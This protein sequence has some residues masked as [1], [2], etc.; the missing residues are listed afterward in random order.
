MISSRT[1]EL[2]NHCWADIIDHLSACLPDEGCGLL[3]GRGDRVQLVYP[4]PNAAAS[5]QRYRMEPQNQLE[6]LYQIDEQG[7]DLVGIFHSHPNG[8]VTPSA[9]DR[10]EWHY[11]ELWMI[12]AAPSKPDWAFGGYILIEGDLVEAPIRVITP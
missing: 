3:A 7:L 10:G 11:N 2:P 8:G 1:L 9:T 12:I 5:S 6:A 4:V